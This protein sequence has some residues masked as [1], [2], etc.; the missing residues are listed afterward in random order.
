MTLGCDYGWE[1]PN[2]A[3]LFAAGYRFA[4]RYLSYDTTGKNLTVDE[5]QAL[6]AAGLS[7]V[8]NWEYAQSAALRGFIQG[9]DDAQAA[10]AQRA[11]IG[12]PNTV[13]VYFSVDFNA[14]AADMPEVLSYV[15]G[16]VSVLG[17]D[18]VG[19]YG[20]DAVIA[21]VANANAC[22]WLWQTYAWSN[23]TWDSRAHIQQTRNGVPFAGVS[24]DQ[25]ESMTVDFGQWEVSAMTQ[26]N[27]GFSAPEFGDDTA[28]RVSA[29]KDMSDTIQGGTYIGQPMELVQA[30][31]RI[32]SQGVANAATL[33]SLT[34][35]VNNLQAAVAQLAAK[36]G[37]TS[38]TLHVAGDL[39]VGQ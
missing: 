8:L 25:D 11:Q 29:M 21:A 23:G 22:K 38:G 37:T 4:C 20:S 19:V 28:W 14:T 34:T 18:G 30:V 31:K 12:A 32:D 5:V 35:A 17:Y 13:P 36:V 33:V 1:R 3:A 6:H 2:P 24:I 39:T 16:C 9:H 27:Y 7:I 26:P 10:R 15:A